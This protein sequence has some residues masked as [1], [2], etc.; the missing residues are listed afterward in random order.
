[1]MEYLKS[2]GKTLYIGFLDYEKAFDF[3]SRS[4][5]ITHLQEKGAGAKFVRAI[6]IMYTSTL[7]VPKMCNRAGEAIIAK[8][9]VTQGR[10]TSSS[11]FSFEVHEMGKS[12]NEP[13]SI[14]NET[15]LLQLADDSGLLTEGRV[16]L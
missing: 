12:I 14:I 4:H 16:L 15:N 11:L 2:I 8:H 3:I 10:Q 7:Y 6:A 1:M 5:L 13:A 9:G